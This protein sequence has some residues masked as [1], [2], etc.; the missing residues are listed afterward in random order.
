MSI[1]N[2][3][4][5][6][7]A[8]FQ[9]KIQSNRTKSIAK[10]ETLL[11]EME[12]KNKVREQDLAI[13]RRYQEEKIKTKELKKAQFRNTLAGRVVTNIK[14][15]VNESKKKNKNRLRN[16]NNIL[17]AK[18]TYSNPFSSSG[19][20][21]SDPFTKGTIERNVFSSSGE[22]KPKPMKKRVKIIEY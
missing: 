3:I 15:K 18:N 14:S 20:I 21:G 7:K 8:K 9:N 6:K 5:Q 12:I 1:I 10:K 16:D 13:E 22:I 17:N 4:A 19:S 11:K 2:Y